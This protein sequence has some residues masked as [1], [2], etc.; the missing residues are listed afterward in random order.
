MLLMKNKIKQNQTF[1]KLIIGIKNESKL[2]KCN[3][4]DI[5]DF[6]NYILDSF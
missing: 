3:S 6:Y 1:I 2:Y 4:T 5:I